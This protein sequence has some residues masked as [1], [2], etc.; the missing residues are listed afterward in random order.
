LGFTLLGFYAAGPDLLAAD[1]RLAAE[2]DSPFAA[3]NA[4][5]WR[6]YGDQRFNRA[7]EAGL[8]HVELDVT[9]DEKRQQPVVTHD[10]KPRGD[11]PLLGDLLAR[12]WQQWGTAPDDGYT[13]IIDFKTSQPELALAVGELLKPHA[14]L[15][16]QA[17]KRNPRKFQPG[18]ISVCL[19][20]NT[21]AHRHYE[22]SVPEDG[23][24]LAFGDQ[25]ASGWVEDSAKYV[26]NESAGFVRFLTFERGVFMDR[27]GVKDNAHVSPERLRAVVRLANERGYRIRVYTINPPSQDEGGRDFSYWEK[28]VDSGVHMIATDA[29]EISR[30]WWQQRQ[31]AAGS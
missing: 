13:V 19:T 17:P 2:A 18:R 5:P 28:C 1:A 26:P 14:S 10:S 31:A 3:H 15:L 12:L 24:Y 29:Y 30:D 4:Y 22:K 23:T 20:G 27:K 11:E 21:A 8:K 9:Y 16:S 7:L 6:L 25:G